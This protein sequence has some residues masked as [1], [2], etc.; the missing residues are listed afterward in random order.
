MPIFA[1]LYLI[2]TMGSAGLPG[3]SG[4][5]G[6]FLTIFGTFTAAD[7]FP[8]THPN[9]LPSPR[10]LGAL[11]GTGVILGAVYL[12]YM[13]QKIFFGPIDPKKNGSLKDL[14]T[15]ELAVFIPLCV[16]IVLMGLFPRPFLRH[17]EK[18]VQ[19]FAS[20]YKQKLAEPDGPAHIY[21]Q[22]APNLSASSAAG[23]TAPSAVVA[24]EGGAQ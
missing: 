23:R 5:T 13:F 8:G 1:G 6:E 10:L 14:S 22:A 17:M 19:G 20:S 3:T 21:G 9:F 15:R 11:A 12:L 4:F 2:I 7:T 24:H 16:G 18:S